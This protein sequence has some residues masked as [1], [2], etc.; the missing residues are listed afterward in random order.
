MASHHPDPIFQTHDER[1]RAIL[2]DQV[3]T[4]GFD[5]QNPYAESDAT[6]WVPG[7]G[8]LRTGI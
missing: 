7:A 2:G 4:F 1:L 5:S 6:L 3:G 8:Y